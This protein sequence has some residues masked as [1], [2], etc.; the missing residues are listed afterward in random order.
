MWLPGESRDRHPGV[1]TDVVVKG[2]RA[3]KV[4]AIDTLNGFEQEL[5]FRQEGDGVAVP[6]VLVRDYPLMIKIAQV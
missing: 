4:V 5:E 2:V 3:G 6:N 1:K